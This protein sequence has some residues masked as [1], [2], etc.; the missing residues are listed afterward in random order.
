MLLNNKI[1]GTGSIKCKHKFLV[2]NL[3][4]RGRL[5]YVDTELEDVIKISLSERGW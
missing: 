1:N 4:G 5:E 2:K 3:K